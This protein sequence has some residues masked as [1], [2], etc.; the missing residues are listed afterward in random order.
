[1]WLLLIYFKL[2]LIFILF[3]SFFFTVFNLYCFQEISDYIALQ[4]HI[5][6]STTHLNGAEFRKHHQ[7]S[8]LCKL[9]SKLFKRKWIFISAEFEIP[10]WASMRCVATQVIYTYFADYY[11]LILLRKLN[12][13]MYNYKALKFKSIN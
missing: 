13:A 1:M 9:I 11:L 12:V 8:N 2:Y 4:N 5:T 3:P 6:P 7:R 10:N